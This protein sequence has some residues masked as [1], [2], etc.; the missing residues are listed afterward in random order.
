MNTFISTALNP[1]S[2]GCLSCRYMLNMTQVGYRST[3]PAPPVLATS[4]LR[5]PHHLREARSS[6]SSP[7]CRPT[8]ECTF[9]L[10]KRP[11]RACQTSLG[12]RHSLNPASRPRSSTHSR[13]LAR[14]RSTSKITTA[15]T[16]LSPRY[17]TPTATM[18]DADIEANID[19]LL[20]FGADQLD[21]NEARQLL[22]VWP[23]QLAICL[24]LA[25]KP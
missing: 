11:V 6:R 8:H 16:S 25:T 17:T 12:D 1:W 10:Y 3:T 19:L 5:C 23:K 24:R 14:R 13:P 7:P 21:R 18:A 2:I 4:S 15:P 20:S 9:P 22:A